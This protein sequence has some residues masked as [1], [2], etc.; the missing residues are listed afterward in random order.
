MVNNII[1]YL[2]QVDYPWELDWYT[3]VDHDV[4]DQW[5]YVLDSRHLTPDTDHVFATSQSWFLIEKNHKL[6]TRRRMLN[7]KR[8]GT[9]TEKVKYNGN[10]NADTEK[11][12]WSQRTEEGTIVDT[13]EVNNSWV[14]KYLGPIFV[15]GGGHITDVR[16]RITNGENVVQTNTSHVSRRHDSCLCID[17]ILWM[18]L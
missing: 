12:K 16:R 2:W 14:F 15:T 8:C 17:L 4:E 7:V 6:I 13:V 11:M 9:G 10:T 5:E 3:S 1:W 18:C